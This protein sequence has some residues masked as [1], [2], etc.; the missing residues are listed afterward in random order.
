MIPRQA[1]THVPTSRS[2]RTLWCGPFAIATISR[3]DYDA[4]YD[5]AKAVSGKDVVRGL[6]VS[7]MWP[8]I[9]RLCGKTF[10]AHEEFSG[11][12]RPPGNWIG[13]DGKSVSFGQDARPTFAAWLK[14][15]D[16]K[17]VYLVHVSHHYVVVAGD[18]VI[19]NQ[20]KDWTPVSKSKHRR[21]RVENVWRIAD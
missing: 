9:Y 12:G 6:G 21:R 1:Q 14:T 5:A 7:K 17:R 16:R 11:R 18:R 15:R 20:M 10:D 2:G 19:D 3:T 8:A 13:D 4:A